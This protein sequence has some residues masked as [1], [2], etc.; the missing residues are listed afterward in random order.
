MAA[1]RPEIHPRPR[2]SAPFT[3]FFL[4]SCHLQPRRTP[5][6]HKIMLYFII[7][8]K[9]VTKS[10]IKSL[11]MPILL[12]FQGFTYQ[13]FLLDILY[14]LFKSL[15]LQLLVCIPFSEVH[16]ESVSYVPFR[17]IQVLCAV[18]PQHFCLL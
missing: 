6:S 8:H 14:F 7:C 3:R 18:L 10:I 13:V 12:T 15:F 5:E 4:C 11:G 9:S 16:Q 2:V 17:N 1:A